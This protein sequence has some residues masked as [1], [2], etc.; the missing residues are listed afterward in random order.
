LS[1]DAPHTALGDSPA[2]RIEAQDFH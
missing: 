1:A 2:G